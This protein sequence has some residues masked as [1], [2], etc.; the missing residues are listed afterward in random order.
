MVSRLLVPAVVAMSTAAAGDWPAWRG[1]DGS[2]ISSEA[3]L[4]VKW[5]VGEN[6]RWRVALPEPGN[7]T[8]IVS[9]GR[10]FLTQ[11][12]GGRRTLMCFDRTDGRLLWREGVEGKE[13]E[14]THKTNPYCSPSPV[15]DGERVIAWFGSDGLHCFDLKGK[16]LWSR[17]LGAQRHIWGYGAS[18]VIWRDLCLLNFGPG[19]RTFLIA[20]DKRTGRT[21]WRHDEDTGYTE[22]N[23]GT[24]RDSKTYIGS[25]STPVLMKVEGREQVLMSWPNRLAAHD[26]ASG[27]I[28]WTCSGLNPLVYTSPIHAGGIVVTMGG[29]GGSGFA[30]RAGG[31]GDITDS[32]RLWHQPK[33]RQRIGSG[34]IH[35]GRIFIHT[36]PGFVECFDLKTGA[37][38]WEQRI[39][40]SRASAKNWSSILL[41]GGNGY[42][43]TQGG[44]CFVFKAGPKFELVAVNTLGES[45]NSSVAPSDGELFIRTHRALWCIGAAR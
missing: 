8:P 37:L 12:E 43:I 31:N 40:G 29:F 21:V 16:M 33:S 5:G 28:Q 34:V 15:A 30:V 4:P 20:V 2:G 39:E 11:A 24:G 38:V 3:T 10:V 9:G 25:W 18:P 22:V 26:P 6:V 41:A 14:P 1:P 35:D 7:S 17:D 13:A 23:P 45:S 44:D 36:D 32:R 27:K 42:T 19:E